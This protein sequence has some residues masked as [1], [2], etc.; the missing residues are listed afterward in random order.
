MRAEPQPFFVALVIRTRAGTAR[1]NTL[2]SPDPV[3]A[4]AL[5]RA[6]SATCGSVS[7]RGDPDLSTLGR[8]RS[9]S[10]HA[11]RD[12][13]A[14]DRADA[15]A[16]PITPPAPEGEAALFPWRR[17]LSARGESS[18]HHR[19]ARHP[20][21]RVRCSSPSRTA[22]RRRPRRRKD[23]E[24]DP[25]RPCCVRSDRRARTPSENAAIVSEEGDDPTQILES[26][27]QRA[28]GCGQRDVHE[29]MSRTHEISP[30]HTA[31]TVQPPCAPRP[32]YRSVYR[33]RAACLY[34]ALVRDALVYA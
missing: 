4:A 22:S 29:V 25:R 17:R 16:P 11:R 9:P 23:D 34:F 15:T 2:T 3:Y 12:Y 8:R 27:V 18:N 24:A 32:P 33:R 19:P 28:A 31:I 30:P 10:L 13:S 6:D 14:D 7:T 5:G 20:A 1:P 21:R 26:R